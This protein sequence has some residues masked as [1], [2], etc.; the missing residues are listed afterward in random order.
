MLLQQ[1]EFRSF[2]W[3]RGRIPNVSL[4]DHLFARWDAVAADHGVEKIKSGLPEGTSKT[5]TASGCSDEFGHSQPPRAARNLLSSSTA[6]LMVNVAGSWRGGNSLN[7]SRNW[8]TMA[9]P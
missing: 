3:R 9:D 4:L 7:V 5:T 2:Y 6:W 8:V 1:A